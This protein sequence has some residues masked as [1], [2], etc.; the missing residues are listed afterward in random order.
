[1]AAA[2]LG[3]ILRPESGES[4]TVRHSPI[5][6]QKLRVFLYLD[7][8]NCN[9]CVDPLLSRRSITANDAATN[10]TVFWNPLPEKELVYP[11]GEVCDRHV[12]CRKSIVQ[13]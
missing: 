10:T 8:E 7:Q 9:T 12:Y 11:V 5:I 2:S 6:V 4:T 13:A 3:A 1:M